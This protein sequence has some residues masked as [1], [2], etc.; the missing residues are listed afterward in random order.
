MNLGYNFP[1]TFKLEIGLLA[2]LLK[3]ISNAEKLVGSIQE[4]SHRTGIPTG[5]Q[6]G[7]VEPIISYAYSCGLIDANKEKGLWSLHLTSL[8]KVILTEDEI[9]NEDIS[10]YMMHLM[11][12]RV[13]KEAPQQGINAAWHDVFIASKYALSDKFRI[14]QLEQFIVNKRGKKGYLRNLINLIIASYDQNNFDAPFSKIKVLDVNKFEDQLGA[15]RLSAPLE[16][17]FFPAYSAFL[18]LE[19]DRLFEGQSQIS[20]DE[21][22]SLT[23]WNLVLNWSNKHFYRLLDWI[24]EKGFIQVDRL[25][26]SALLLR[27][28]DTETVLEDFFSELI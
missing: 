24:A 13:D 23:R 21:F 2:K 26:G 9:L 18:F 27:L 17:S 15:I 19:W 4:I 22:L 7:K 11:M 6:S 1:T 8:G 3:E 25:T 10:L 16:Y 12:N 20:F 28:T 14:D 5:S